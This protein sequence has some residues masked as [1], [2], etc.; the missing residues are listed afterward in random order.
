MEAGRTVK[1]RLSRMR[2]VKRLSSGSRST[3]E[4]LLDIPDL[5]RRHMRM[6]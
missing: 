6:M 1:G 4:E 5:T 2:S 3:V